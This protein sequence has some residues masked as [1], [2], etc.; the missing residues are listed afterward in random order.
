MALSEQKQKYV[1]QLSRKG[2]M[3]SQSG[4]ERLND[5]LVE[6]ILDMRHPPMYVNDQ[7]IDYMKG[8]DVDVGYTT[9]EAKK[10]IKSFTGVD[11]KVYYLTWSE[12]RRL[13]QANADILVN[14]GMA[15]RA[16]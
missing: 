16:S 3:L 11:G 14:R 9:I 12:E 13:P 10:N 7:F 5:K 4:S 6:R 15:K 2:I 8:R 1:K